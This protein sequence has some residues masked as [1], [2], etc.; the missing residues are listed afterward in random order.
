MAESQTPEEINQHLFIA[1]FVAMQ[2]LVSFLIEELLGVPY[3]IWKV[4]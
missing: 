1:R 3:L 4:V 2:Y